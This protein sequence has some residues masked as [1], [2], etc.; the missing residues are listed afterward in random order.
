MR[1]FAS[2]L[3]TLILIGLLIY[4]IWQISVLRKEVASLRTEVAQL[5]I[6]SAAKPS[7]ASSL[8]EIRSHVELAREFAVKGNFEKARSELQKSL[9]GLEKAGRDASAP[10]L[11][12]LQSVQKKMRDTADNIQK[13]LEKIGAEPKATKGSNGK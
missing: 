6:M 1:G 7:S 12:A 13:L 10:S 5:K 8:N 11:N 9:D 2:K 3:M 4:G